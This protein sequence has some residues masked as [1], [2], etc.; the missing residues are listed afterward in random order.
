MGPEGWVTAKMSQRIIK[1]EKMPIVISEREKSSQEMEMQVQRMH[2]LRRRCEVRRGLKMKK[3]I[4]MNRFQRTKMK[5][6]RSRGRWK[7]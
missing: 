6:K 1:T 4:A 7:M 2:R 3:G 5:E